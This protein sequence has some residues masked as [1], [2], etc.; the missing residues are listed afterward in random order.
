M[1]KIKEAKRSILQIMPA[2]GWVAVFSDNDD[3]GTLPDTTR[4]PLFAWAV[5]REI[6]GKKAYTQ[7]TGL[8]INDEGQVSEACWTVGFLR[9]ERMDELSSGRLQSPGK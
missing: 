3:D 8:F 4:A 9:Y 2:D 1:S 7:V 5:V 6:D